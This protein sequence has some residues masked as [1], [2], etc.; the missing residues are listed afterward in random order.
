MS[1]N[2]KKKPDQVLNPIILN[3]IIFFALFIISGLLSVWDNLFEPLIVIL[4][5]GWFLVVAV[6]SLRLTQRVRQPRPCPKSAGKGCRLI[7]WRILDQ[8]SWSKI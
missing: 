4:F 6:A 2:P 3:I 8:V 7:G 1:A 5:A